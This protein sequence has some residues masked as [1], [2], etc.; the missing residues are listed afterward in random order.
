[1]RAT[2]KNNIIKMFCILGMVST[3][4]LCAR[5]PFGQ[6]AQADTYSI[7]PADIV[8]WN[9]DGN[10]L[11]MCL[12][13]GS[14]CYAYKKDECFDAKKRAYLALDNIADVRIVK[15]GFYIIDNDGEEYFFEK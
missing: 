15:N 8:D 1:M 5:Q 7:D 11:S 9:T 6:T 4:T 12:S 14:E 13:D 10:E 3:F 2:F